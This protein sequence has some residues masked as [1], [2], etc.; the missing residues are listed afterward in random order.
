ML[1][2]IVDGTTRGVASMIETAE[3]LARERKVVLVRRRLKTRETKSNPRERSLT[4]V[5]SINR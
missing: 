5:A 2:F 4:V 3:Y 1:L